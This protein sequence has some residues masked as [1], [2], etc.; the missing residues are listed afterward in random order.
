MGLSKEQL[1]AK[2]KKAGKWKDKKDRVLVVQRIPRGTQLMN[3]SKKSPFGQKFTSN[4]R[5]C[6]QIA[7]TPGLT[8]AVHSFRINSMFDPDLTGTGHQP[9]FRDIMSGIYSRY[10]VNY[11]KYR[12][13]FLQRN[14][15]QTLIGVFATQ[16]SS[17]NPS[18]DQF[19]EIIEKRNTKWAF[20]NVNTK[21]VVL[22]G[23]L[24][25]SKVAAVKKATY[26]AERNYTA[27]VGSNP[28]L[29]LFLTIFMQEVLSATATQD[30]MIELDY[31]TT[32]Y[33]PVVQAQN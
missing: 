14:A 13:T 33:E 24:S 8:A 16:D 15:N 7:I 30:L 1:K 25:C 17:Y 31:N 29:P 10:R 22:S 20:Q 2:L 5:Y 27:A 9:L 11:V 21:P 6:Q 3:S 18:L 32:Y 28:T 12:V 26:D 23:T 4:Y 19:Q